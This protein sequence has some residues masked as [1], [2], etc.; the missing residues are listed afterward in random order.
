LCLYYFVLLH[1]YQCTPDLFQIDEKTGEI[2]VKTKFD[3]EELLD[4]LA[5]V[6]LDINVSLLTNEFDCVLLS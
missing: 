2:S 1:R 3:R 6:T 4:I 5:T